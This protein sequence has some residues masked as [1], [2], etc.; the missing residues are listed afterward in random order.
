[1]ECFMKRTETND[2]R[3]GEN[4]RAKEGQIYYDNQ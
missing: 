4:G 2:S 3:N 1:M